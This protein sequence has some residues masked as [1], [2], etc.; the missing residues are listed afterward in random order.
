[1]YNF[2]IS[3]LKIGVAYTR[4]DTWINKATENNKILISN[5][6]KKLV[7]LENVELFSTEDLDPYRKNKYINGREILQSNNKYLTD[8]QDAVNFAD[9]FKKCKIDALVVVFCNY[10]QEEAIAKLAKELNVP[11]LL[12]APS[13]S[14]DNENDIYRSTDSQCGVFAASKVLRRYGIKFSY[15]DN[16]QIDAIEFSNGLKQFFKTSRIVKNF[17]SARIAQVSV[18]PQQFVNLMVNEG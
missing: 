11:V 1:M 7:E 3:N 10:G 12:W 17:R 9:Y 13:D 6:I 15:I 8:Y 5:K 18:R 14:I 16:C 2:N 4:R